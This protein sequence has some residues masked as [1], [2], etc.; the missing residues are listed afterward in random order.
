MRGRMM[1]LTQLSTKGGPQLGE[2]ESGLVAQWLGVPLAI[3][4]GGAGCI[5]AA[6]L[7]IRRFPKLLKLDRVEAVPVA[8]EN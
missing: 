3:I 5:V 2:V 6:W 7:V 4:T 8:P 1:S